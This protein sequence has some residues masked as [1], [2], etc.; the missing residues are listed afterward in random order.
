MSNLGDWH[1]DSLQESINTV[2]NFAN[3]FAKS[4]IWMLDKSTYSFIDI[5]KKPG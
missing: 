5:A 1:I 3:F 4:G 2:R